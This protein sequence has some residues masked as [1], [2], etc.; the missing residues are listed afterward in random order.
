[1]TMKRN[2]TYLSSLL[3]AFLA[4]LAGCEK[5]DVDIVQNGTADVTLVLALDGTPADF[6]ISESS[7]RTAMSSSF[8]KASSPEVL[9]SEGLR[10]LRIIVT[11]GIPGNPGFNIV[12]NEK[13]ADAGSSS[14]A[15]V[16]EYGAV[17]LPDIPVGNVN[18]YCIG[19]EESVGMTYDNETIMS[20]LG[21]EPKLIVIDDTNGFFPKANAEIDEKGLPI[22]G[23][24]MNVAVSDG[25]GAVNID[26]ERTVVKL[27]L[28]VENATTSDLTLDGISFGKFSGDRFY[29]FPTD[30]LDVP[31]DTQY[32]PLDFGTMSAAG[33]SA[34]WSVPGRS[35]SAPYRVYIYPTYAYTSGLGDNP[36]WI[37]LYL[38]PGNLKYEQGTFGLGYNS[39]RRNTQVNIRARIT[40][41]TD[42]LIDF[43]V[44]PWDEYTVNV[45]DF[46]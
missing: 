13:I 27:N 42:V 11:Q 5:S 6:E 43:E 41:T 36:Y 29:M 26:L 1:M 9:S 39:F 44:L 7:G 21:S 3:S 22:S 8:T 24:R 12:Y 37:S 20:V 17:T 46:E 25:M 18:I 32:N 19:N 31:S 14:A 2:I 28:V 4:L 45:P 30:R 15:P 35:D 40:S 10:T 33:I 34:G 23:Y 38:S 16:L